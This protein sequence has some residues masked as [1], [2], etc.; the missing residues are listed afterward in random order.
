MSGHTSGDVSDG[1]ESRSIRTVRC[2]AL[3]CRTRTCVAPAS[4][5][6]ERQWHMKYSSCRASSW[7]L[8]R[9]ASTTR[10]VL[11]VSASTSLNLAIT[12]TATKPSL[13][14][15]ETRNWSCVAPMRHNSKLI[16]SIGM[17][18]ACGI[19]PRAA[20]MAQLGNDKRG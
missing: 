20:L 16:Q 12:S 1:M 10:A 6:P 4:S 15:M 8:L 7:S 11:V 2:G 9:M 18:A 3:K 13:F 5:C 14:I 19:A 17:I